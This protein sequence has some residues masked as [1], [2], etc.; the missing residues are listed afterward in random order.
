MKNLLRNIIKQYA[1]ELFAAHGKSAGSFF[2]SSA[3][4]LAEAR[5]EVVY[6]FSHVLQKDKVFILSHGE[7]VPTDAELQAFY[8][9]FARRKAGEP[10]AYL[11]GH[12]E[13]YGYE[14]A[15]DSS[16]LIPRADTEV[17]VDEANAYIKQ[18]PGTAS[19]CD[20][21]TGTGC[22]LLSVL[23][24]NANAVGVGIDINEN[25]VRLAQKNAERLGCENRSTFIRGDFTDSEF[26]DDFKGKCVIGEFDCIISNPPYIPYSEYLLLDESVRRYEPEA[27][28]V[29][30]E[31]KNGMQGLYHAQAV[32]RL[33]EKML[34]PGGLLL[35]EHGYNQGR[36]MRELCAEYAFAEI[37]T[38]RDLGENDRVLRALK[39]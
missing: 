39:K 18:F 23:L 22:I 5:S 29:S 30:A 1:E 27:A 14:F 16:A 3:A 37:K 11:L 20:L 7:Y 34:R 12:K 38:I 36:P 21:G 17:L 9:L 6:L 35:I 26:W 31:S 4:S 15:V 2:S 13:F 10:I 33:A 25:A 28:L 32:L 24:E 8:A 19:V